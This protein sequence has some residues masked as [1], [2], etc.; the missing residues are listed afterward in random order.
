MRQED[1]GLLEYGGE[2][3]REVNGGQDFGGGEFRGGASAKSGGGEG[4]KET[5]GGL[6][7]S[8]SIHR[9]AFRSY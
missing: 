2:G 3:K 6:S 4:G 8:Q 5:G 9:T 1:G 7:S